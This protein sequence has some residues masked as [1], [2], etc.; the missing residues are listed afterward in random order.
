M[1]NVLQ[2]NN[3]QR[4]IDLLPEV[5]LLPTITS[6]PLSFVNH[7]GQLITDPDR[8]VITTTT[9]DEVSML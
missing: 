2:L 1:N 8:K 3:Q 9:S 7:L 5:G 6:S 4:Y